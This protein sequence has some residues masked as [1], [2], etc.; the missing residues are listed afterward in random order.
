MGI[1]G[2]EPR[3]SECLKVSTSAHSKELFEQDE[4]TSEEES[5]DD[6]DS[7]DSENEDRSPVAR[8]T[9]TRVSR[10]DIV[11]SVM[12]PVKR[13]LVDGIMDEF[14]FLFGS[15]PAVRSHAGSEGTSASQAA[16]FPSPA[17]GGRGFTAT[18][19]SPTHPGKPR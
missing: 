19:F 2:T 8:R 1:G 3:D 17:S 10:D 18:S 4:S 13:E 15:S 11:G 6:E 12:T 14:R 16:S 9:P 7:S 5:S